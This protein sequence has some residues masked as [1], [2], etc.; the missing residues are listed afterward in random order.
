MVL[1]FSLLFYRLQQRKK[2]CAVCK[3]A[4]YK[5]QTELEV[6]D[7]DTVDENVMF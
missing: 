2:P 5:Q 6:R 4:M 1:F 7:C 3:S